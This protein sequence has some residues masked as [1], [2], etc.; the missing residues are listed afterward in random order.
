MKKSKAETAQTRKRIL[1]VASQAFKSNGIE[2]TGVAEVMSAVGLTHGGFYRHFGSKEQLVAEACGISLAG[3]VQGYEEA[4]EGG[5]ESFV[6]HIQSHLSP[7][8]RDDRENGCPIVAMGSELVRA[9][10]ATRAT[11]SKGLRELLDRIARWI[12]G[13]DRDLA[14]DEAIIVLTNMIGAV[15]VSRI[16]DDEK[17]SDRILDVVRK[18]I[19]RRLGGP[20][21]RQR[22]KR[23][24]KAA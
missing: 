19:G 24:K 18:Q 14:A 2:A 8:Y 15:T 20:V 17:L 16:V 7:E 1:E 6:K 4:A 13:K 9:D 5:R 22:Q 10:D 3:L 21:S 23:R 11:A 12:P